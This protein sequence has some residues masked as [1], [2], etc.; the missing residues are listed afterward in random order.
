MSLIPPRV[1]AELSLRR[2]PQSIGG[3]VD[4]S[5]RVYGV[6]GLRVIDSSIVPLSLSAH[7]T[8]P[9]YGIS[10]NA[11]DILV[12]TPKAIGGTTLSSSNSG[13]QS[14][15]NTSSTV[16]RR[17]STTTSGGS[18]PT[19]GSQNNTNGGS[20]LGFSISALL[21]GLVCFFN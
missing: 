5:L 21:V 14:N 11:Y 6:S 4:S 17:S 7:M 16:T 18:E 12:S 20:K 15:E 19:T 1:S 3:V 2:R 13:S 8:S 10:E 9:L